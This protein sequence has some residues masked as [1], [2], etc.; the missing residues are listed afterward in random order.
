MTCGTIHL[1]VF[2]DGTM[3][4]SMAFHTYFLVDTID[5][6]EVDHSGHES[7]TFT[8][9]GTNGAAT[10]TATFTPVTTADLCARLGGVQPQCP[11]G[12]SIK[13]PLLEA[14]RCAGFVMSA[15]L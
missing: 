11:E 10:T 2:A 7:D 14:T 12:L 6:A 3:H 9:E 15:T 13:V 4:V 8:F 5:P 1:T